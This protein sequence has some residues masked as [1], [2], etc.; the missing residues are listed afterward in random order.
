MAAHT[1]S[2]RRSYPEIIRPEEKSS[3]ARS[4]A[5]RPMAAK[6]SGDASTI[7]CM[8]ASQAGRVPGLNQC[9][10]NPVHQKL[11]GSP[12]LWH[13]SPANRKPLPPT[14]PK[15]NPSRNE[16][17]TK[18]SS[19]R[20]TR[21]ISRSVAKEVHLAL[22]IQFVDQILQLSRQFSG[23]GNQ[24]MC[25]PMVQGNFTESH[26]SRSSGFLPAKVDL[27]CQTRTRQ[28]CPA[29]S[30][31]GRLLCSLALKRNHSQVR[32]EWLQLSRPVNTNCL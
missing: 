13:Q 26:R 10:P 31:F 23:T 19:A 32:F 12:Q 16:G 8:A 15:A 11:R 21:G 1:C 29:E 14:W 25:I 24:Q 22:Q 5:T 18:T 17:K 20:S 2:Y 3:V 27:R 9:S 6:R 7:S 30:H 4:L 28:F